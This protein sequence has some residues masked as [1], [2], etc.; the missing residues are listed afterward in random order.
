MGM[1]EETLASVN[2]VE[3]CEDMFSVFHESV[4]SIFRCLPLRCIMESD[5]LQEEV[6]CIA[7]PQIYQEK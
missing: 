1:S 6:L 7:W 2:H 5:A 3:T 4:Q